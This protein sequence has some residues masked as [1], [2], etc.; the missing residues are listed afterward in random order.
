MDFSIIWT[1]DGGLIIYWTK[2]RT[3]WSRVVQ[4]LVYYI[5][6]H[7][8]GDLLLRRLPF[9]SLLKC[10]KRESVFTW[11]I[12]GVD[13]SQTSIKKAYSFLKRRKCRLG[14]STMIY[15][16]CIYDWIYPDRYPEYLWFKTLTHFGLKLQNP[17]RHPNI[18]IV[19][20]CS[21]IWNQLPYGSRW[22]CYE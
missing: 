18:C 8:E 17:C 11:P 2:N 1:E 7:C 13:L 10:I 16:N 4:K 19:E 9:V 3:E 15:G 12:H 6:V 5:D 22:F 14:Q 21:V 20:K